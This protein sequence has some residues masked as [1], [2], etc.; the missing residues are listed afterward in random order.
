MQPRY[1]VAV[2]TQDQRTYHPVEGGYIEAVHYAMHADPG[3]EYVAVE[4]W[5]DTANG[6][7]GG[8]ITVVTVRGDA[9]SRHAVAA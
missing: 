6:C 5:S 9:V 2:R 4:L 1:Q 8:W 3:S 7:T